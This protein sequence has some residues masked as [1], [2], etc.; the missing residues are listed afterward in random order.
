VKQVK[1]ILYVG[2]CVVCVIACTV[3]LGLRVFRATEGLN[4][5]S[6]TPSSGESKRIDTLDAQISSQ[7]TTGSRI[8][9]EGKVCSKKF[10][11]IASNVKQI[12]SGVNILIYKQGKDAYVFGY[13]GAGALG[14][15]EENV[16]NGIVMEPSC[17]A[18]N[19]ANVYASDSLVAYKKDGQIYISGDG[20]YGEFYPYTEAYYVPKRFPKEPK[21][22]WLS[23]GTIAYGLGNDLYLG[24]AVIYDPNR[25]VRPRQQKR[26]LKKKLNRIKDVAVG[27]NFVIVQYKN[28]KAEIIGRNEES[29]IIRNNN[30][31]FYNSFVPLKKFRPNVKK[32][33]VGWSNAGA[34]KK[35]GD[36]YIWG[37]NESGFLRDKSRKK[38]RTKPKL[39]LTNVKDVSMQY[40][41]V[42]ALKKNGTVW[43]WGLNTGYGISS[44]YKTN[45]VITKPIKI[46]SG[47]KSIATG[48]GFSII[49]K[50][51][52]TAHW[53]GTIR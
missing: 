28:G 13:N 38:V 1:K 51:N 22:V 15:G 16:I 37:S 25:E 8:N 34:I 17:I 2:V 43:A 41:H 6:A 49:L 35:N 4:D 50:K 12:E 20:Y 47:V 3:V 24:G 30:R 21:K 10:K 46:A 23:Q 9:G 27:S 18:T 53:K 42:L 40:D 26:K 7:E 19:V 44:K 29:R 5:L 32:Y 45:K 14:N 31:Y 39:V 11:K 52:G 48:D 36:F 33:V